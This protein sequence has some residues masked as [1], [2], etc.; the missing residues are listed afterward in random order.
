MRTR[1]RTTGG[2]G[3]GKE[4]DGRADGGEEGEAGAD[5]RACR[6]TH[7]RGLGSSSIIIAG[8]RVGIGT[9]T[10]G[11]GRCV[12]LDEHPINNPRAQSTRVRLRTILFQPESQL[13]ASTTLGGSCSLP[14][15]TQPSLQPPW[16]S[17]NPTLSL[18]VLHPAS[19]TTLSQACSL[20]L[21]GSVF[22]P[23]LLLPSCPSHLLRLAANI[24]CSCPPRSRLLLSIPPPRSGRKREQ[25]P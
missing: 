25:A 2:R 10:N 6:Q 11:G 7:A 18:I 20:S 5:G 19:T 16:A 24:P 3:G 12:N 13:R 9:C 22:P 8:E 21:L 1:E 15:Q 17:P 4:E 14:N 23:A